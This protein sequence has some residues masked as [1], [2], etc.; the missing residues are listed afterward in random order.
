MKYTV[1]LD[2][3]ASNGTSLQGYI[4]TTFHRLCQILGEPMEG[5]D[6]TTAEWII[7]FADGTVATIYDWKTPVTPQHQYQWHVGGLSPRAV[8]LVHQLFD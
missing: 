4:E 5:G 3:F 2:L 1:N 8:E 7:E 6:K